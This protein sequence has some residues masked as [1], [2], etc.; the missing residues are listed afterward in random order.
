MYKVESAFNAIGKV[1]TNYFLEYQLRKYY[2]KWHRSLF[3]F[4][5][6]ACTNEDPRVNTG[7]EPWVPKIN[8][9]CNGE[10]KSMVLNVILISQC[11]F[12]QKTIHIPGS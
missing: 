12:M 5:I 2:Y 3:Y 7:Y 9:N 11:S 10:N 8:T 6:H 1:L 4:Q